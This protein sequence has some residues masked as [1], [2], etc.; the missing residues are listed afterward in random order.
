MKNNL[1]IT[2]DQLGRVEMFLSLLLQANRELN[3]I[4]RKDEQ[5]IWKSHILHSISLAFLC[6]FDNLQSVL[7]LGTGGGLPGIPLKILFPSLKFTLVDSIRKKT[8][9]VERIVTE[10]GLD[11]VS[12]VCSRAEDLPQK[13]EFKNAFDAIVCRAV[14]PLK[15]LAGWSYP[16]LKLDGGLRLSVAGKMAIHPGTLISFKGGDVEKEIADA[17]RNFNIRSIEE[18]PLVF[19]GSESLSLVDK[20]I[21]V[22]QF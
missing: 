8:K 3:L 22:V 12:V 18:I 16:L 2:D 6:S 11:G 19:H 9:A 5:N 7:D 20:K 21:V 14:A 17:K 1:Q 13:R 4:S 15:K 10:L